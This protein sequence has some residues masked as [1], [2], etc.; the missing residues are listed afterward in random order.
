MQATLED[1]QKLVTSEQKSCKLLDASV[2]TLSVSNIRG[3]YV[4]GGVMIACYR[5]V[6]QQLYL[7]LNF[8]DFGSDQN[9]MR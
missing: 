5:Y 9:A 2:K 7:T 6:R 1:F 8:H 3:L 4:C